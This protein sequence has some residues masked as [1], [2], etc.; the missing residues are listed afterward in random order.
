MSTE[1][2]G[3][4]FIVEGNGALVHLGKA[5]AFLFMQLELDIM[6]VFII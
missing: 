1:V 4:R 6:N 5:V 2:A 3:D